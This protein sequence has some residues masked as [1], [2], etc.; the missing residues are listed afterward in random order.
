MGAL[1]FIQSNA[2]FLAAG[3][4]LMFAS[5]FGQTFFI[6]TFAGEIMARFSLSDG[7]WGGIYTIGTCASAVAMFWAGALTDRFRVRLLAWAILPGLALSCFLMAFNPIVPGPK[8][9]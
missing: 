6:S 7:Q 4:L 9:W 5:S 8:P 3:I 1:R 2:R